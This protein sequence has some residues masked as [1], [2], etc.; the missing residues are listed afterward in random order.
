M[1]FW[2]TRLLRRQVRANKPRPP[3]P[4]RP[5]LELLEDRVVPTVG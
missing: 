3:I 4:F 1:T 5:R 2:T